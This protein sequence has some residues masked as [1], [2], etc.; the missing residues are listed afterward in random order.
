MNHSRFDNASRCTATPT[1]GNAPTTGTVPA[2]PTS[3]ARRNT[4]TSAAAATTL[5]TPHNTERVVPMRLQKFLARAGVA[6]RRGSENLMTAGRV[7]V[8][9]QVVVELGSKVHPLLDTVTVDDVAVVW[10]SAP[11]TLAFHKPAGVVSTML[12][13]QGRPCVADY[14]DTRAFPGLYPIGRLDSNTTGLLLFSTDG[15]LGHALL[16]PSH[17]V[18]KRYIVLVEGHVSTA[19]IRAFREGVAIDGYTCA[20][21]DARCLPDARAAYTRYNLECFRS[22]VKN[23]RQ[24]AAFRHALHN[25]AFSAVEL[26]IKEGK[27]HQVKRMFS[28]LHHE[29]YAL[30]RQQFGPVS[31]EGIVR[32]T[33]RVLESTLA[34]QLYACGGIAVPASTNPTDDYQES[35]QVNE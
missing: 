35:N 19:D 11:V 29:V 3:P 13:P 1:T 25:G 32:G 31:A 6:S 27:Y 7:R 14:I 21:A 28:A 4:A 26:T 9:G 12:D 22:V 2:A 24:E 8:N 16:H 30:H 23:K 33:Y 18:A 17:H 10:G 20:P 5:P 15:N 34:A